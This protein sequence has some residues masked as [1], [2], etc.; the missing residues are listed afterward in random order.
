MVTLALGIAANAAVFSALDAYFLRPLAYPHGEKLVNVHFGIAKFPHG[1]GD[2]MSAPGYQ[3]LRSV[4][5][6]SSSGLAT[7]LG[8]LT[9]AIPGEPLANDHVAAVTSSTL[10][11]LGVRPLMGRWISPASD[12]VGGPTEVDVSYGL[13]QSAFHGDPH[14]LG[15]TLRVSGNLYTVVGVMP[16]DFAF[17]SRR[18][19]LWAPIVLKPAMLALQ[20][21]GDLNYVMVARLRR[22]ASRAELQTEIGGVLGRLEQS[23]PPEDRKA[24]RR[25]G[26]YISFM[27]L[28]QWLGGTTRGRLLMMQL[29]AGILLLLAAA[30]LV[31]L[32]L[33]RALRRRDEAAL[34]V[35]L[36]AGRRVLLT[37]ALFEAVPLSIAGTLIAWPLTV[38]GVSA[39][40]RFG[41]ASTSTTFDLH[42]SAGILALALTVA[43]VLSG[44]AL[45]PDCIG[46]CTAFRRS[47]PRTLAA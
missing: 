23:M 30:S 28:R 15:H 20:H 27:P 13:W 46:D 31:N 44:A 25:I 33:A 4:R 5:A 37:Q 45:A 2:W 24:F 35:V 8:N 32:A 21:V 43:L 16:L 38:L 26:L 19:Q 29:G 10:E 7:S 36:G 22:S 42:I 12:G 3:G 40:T 47:A 6:L 14:V 17:P 9:V 39:L 18:T 11:T 34:R 41:I 1:G